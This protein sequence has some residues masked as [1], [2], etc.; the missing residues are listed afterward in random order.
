MI[1]KRMA[2]RFCCEDISKIEGYQE[3]VAD[4]T[5]VWHI[6]H[7][8]ETDEGIPGKEL[9]R[10]GEYFRRP[11]SELIFLTKTQ[12][13]RLHSLGKHHSET[14]REKI[15]QALSGEKNP[16]F[17]KHRSEE[18]KQKIS[19]AKCGEKN[20]FFGKRLSAEHKKKIARALLGNEHTLGFH[21]WNDGI[22]SVCARECPPGF[23]RG[24]LPWKKME[25]TEDE[26]AERL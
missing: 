3:A 11:A 24:K 14:T 4:D 16:H 7:K 1:S 2:R 8:R 22:K 13:H 19:Q 10:R 25:K 9:I 15:S 5:Q 18:T 26:R 20:P 17:G 12:H 21:W 6:H 23:V